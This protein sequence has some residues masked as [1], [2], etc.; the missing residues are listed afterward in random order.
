M[1]LYTQNDTEYDKRIQNN[2]LK[3]K[4]HPKCQNTFEQKQQVREHSFKIERYIT[5]QTN[6]YVMVYQ[7]SIIRI[8]YTLYFFVYFIFL[9][10]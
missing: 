9:Y 1:F 3:Y 8:L 5:K 4:T 10:I 7:S 2:T 6:F